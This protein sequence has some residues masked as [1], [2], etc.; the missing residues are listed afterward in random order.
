MQ[1]PPHPLRR[2]PTNSS[3]S[4]T[5][6]LPRLS[7]P[8]SPLRAKSS[9]SLKAEGRRGAITS[10]L[11]LI[12]SGA[13]A[14]VERADSQEALEG[15]ASLHT[16][17]QHDEIAWLDDFDADEQKPRRRRGRGATYL[18]DRVREGRG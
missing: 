18:R 9:A 2:V 6:Q 8:A 10:S 16:A 1:T 12:S 11:S 17:A 13:G 14:G 15:G 4:S 3:S 5:E 7:S